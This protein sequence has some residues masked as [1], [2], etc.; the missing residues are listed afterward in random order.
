[1]D[2]E[3]RYYVTAIQFNKVAGAENRSVP[4]AYDTL[5]AAKAKF[6]TQI[7]TDINNPNVSRTTVILFDS[8]GDVR[9]TECWR[10]E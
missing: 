5:D 10:E 2:S 4:Y 3:I 8:N 7:G 9:L 1:M 6:Y